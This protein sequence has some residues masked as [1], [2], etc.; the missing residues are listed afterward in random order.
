MRIVKS[1]RWKPS[2]KTP[3]P[4]GAGGGVSDR[5]GLRL[6]FENKKEKSAYISY[7]LIAFSIA[8]AHLQ[9]YPDLFEG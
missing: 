4:A 5:G 2:G 8:L 6:R 9:Q 7:N 1:K 3:R